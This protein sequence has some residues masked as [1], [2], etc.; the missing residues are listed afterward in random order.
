MAIAMTRKTRKLAQPAPLAMPGDHFQAVRGGMWEVVNGDGTAGRSRLPLDGIQMAGKTG[1]AQVR[2]ITGSQRGQDGT[3]WRYRDHGLFVFFA[4]TAAPRYAGAVII[5]H[6]FGGSRAAA[7]VAKD[8]LTYLFD[9]P[10]ALEALA[11]M[12]TQWGGNTAERMERRAQR[13]LEAQQEA[14]AA[15]GG[16]R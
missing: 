14:A 10:K 5:E 2:R 13:W 12:E 6:G 15:A 1:T 9:K 4:P 11:A 3:P 7:P 16:S 8:V